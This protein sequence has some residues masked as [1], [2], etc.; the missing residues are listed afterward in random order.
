MKMRCKHFFCNCFEAFLVSFLDACD[1]SKTF[2]ETTIFM[3]DTVCGILADL[4]HERYGLYG[5]SC[6]EENHWKTTSVVDVNCS[7]VLLTTLSVQL[8]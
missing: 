7:S 2:D 4:V 6:L 1:R 3:L 8:Y 5:S